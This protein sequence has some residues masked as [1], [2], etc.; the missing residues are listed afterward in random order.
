MNSNFPQEPVAIVGVGCRYPGGIVDPDHFWRSISRGED[1]IQDIPPDRFDAAALYDPRPGRRGKIAHTQGG[2][3]QEVDRFDAKFFG[4][5]PR[6]ARYIDPQHRL[7]LET[8]YEALWDAGILLE[9][10]QAHST[11]V[12]VGIWSADYESRM[13]RSL[14]DLDVYAT[15]GGG[16][17]TA[18]GRIAFA[19]DFRGPA[20]IVDTACSSSLV[21]VHLA[22]QSLRSGEC[23]LALAG[24]VNLILAP[25]VSVGY[26][27]S[28]LLSTYALCRFGNEE[29][30]GYVRSEGAGMIALK[31]LSHAIRD[32]DRVYAVI[33][34]SAVNNDGKASDLL[35]QPAVD[36]QAAVL[37]AAYRAAGVEPAL[38]DYVECH[39]TGTR[40][41][42]PVEIEALSRVLGPG[43]DP[44]QPL[45]LGSVKTNFG[46]TEAASGVAGL[47]KAALSLYRRRVPPSLHFNT[48]N[49]AIPWADLP[50]R[51]QSETYDFLPNKKALVGVNSFGISA[52]NAH[53]VLEEFELRR[54]RAERKHPT[55]L[56][57]SG[58]DS[59]ALRDQVVAW[60]EFLAKSEDDLSDILYT[61]NLRRSHYARRLAVVGRD[62]NEF[63]RALDQELAIQDGDMGDGPTPGSDQP[64]LVFVFSGQGPRFWPFVH[65][66]LNQSDAFRETLKR[67]DQVLKDLGGWSLLEELARP[68]ESSQLTQTQFAQPALCSIQIAL[69][70]FWRSCGAVPTAVVGHS[71][72]E[73]PAAYV[74][75][76]LSLEDA[77]RVIF[78]RGRLIQTVCGTG[79]MAFV[80]MTSEDLDQELSACPGVTIAAVNSPG[81]TIVSGD[82]AQID[83]LLAALSERGVFCKVLESVDFASHSPQMERIQP[84]M[85]SALKD[86]IRPRESSLAFY[87]TVSASKLPGA[88]LG[89]AYWARNIREPVRFAD[90][91][92]SLA[93]DMPGVFLEIAP[94]PAMSGSVTRCLEDANGP[95]RALY[96]LKR[97][98]A[99]G[100]S[101]AAAAGELYCA[102]IPLRLADFTPRANVTSLPIY[103]YQ[104]KPYW[105]DESKTPAAE[106]T[107]G[108]KVYRMQ[109][110]PLELSA[111]S[112]LKP[113]GAG[114]SNPSALCLI[115]ASG[116]NGTANEFAELCKRGG[117]ETRVISHDALSASLPGEE[118]NGEGQAIAV[119]DFRA[120]PAGEAGTAATDVLV[121]VLSICRTLASR[122]WNC[123]YWLVTEGAVSAGPA[124]QPDLA[125]APLQGFMKTLQLEQPELA[126]RHVDLQADEQAH[127]TTADAQAEWLFRLFS[128]QSSEHQLAIRRGAGAG[129][130]PRGGSRSAHSRSMA[131]GRGGGLPDH[132]R[133][134]EYRAGGGAL[135]RG[136]RRA[137]SLSH[138]PARF[139]ATRN[140]EWRRR[141]RRSGTYQ[142]DS[143]AGS[144]RG[145]HSLLRR[146]HR[147]SGSDPQN[148]R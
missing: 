134:R 140:V 10:R 67:C 82:S 64:G 24:G 111:A 47:I 96:S 1:L 91:I 41:G 126:P 59:G 99:D 25:Y 120:R 65:D 6:E 21:S 51:I 128:T 84:A 119:F 80:E 118:I 132:R 50:L 29:P 74:A 93:A 115:L 20:F 125:L 147:R 95:S 44:A 53:V 78:H 66:R 13:Q 94:H 77:L 142:C 48:P 15:N 14:E 136:T 7:L 103:S 46:H 38:V 60:K 124:D 88:E 117:H 129:R 39:G 31:L 98:E 92:Q 145:P 105:L 49:L 104:K 17:Y 3:L 23:A 106:Q 33:R 75:G 63:I 19:F 143:P 123:R 127:E 138:W 79:K 131:G 144:K 70:E 56:I 139:A 22:C 90:T 141:L 16:R 85:E 18:A 2:F 32:D 57:L 30:G 112:D 68:A 76:A 27:R 28:R 11:G 4:I 12:F 114:D 5:A 72:G 52:T 58:A 43:R 97:D 100:R 81:N 42:D 83:A 8:A 86:T 37:E 102:G 87:S 9:D 35:M 55:P 36:G 130:A 146:R 107:P 89:A 148:F 137:P 69:S 62:R 26:S 109:W 101:L 135:A 113:A 71:M 110:R 45:R 40:A 108:R 61:A 54:S 122:T 116:E 34:G 121:D 133:R 73:V